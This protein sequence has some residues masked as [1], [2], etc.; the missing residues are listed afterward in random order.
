MLESLSSS[1]LEQLGHMLCIF[2]AW[3]FWNS[4]DKRLGRGQNQSWQVIQLGPKQRFCITETLE[5]YHGCLHNMQ[6]C[7]IFRMLWL[8]CEGLLEKAC[9]ISWCCAPSICAST[10]HWNHGKT[11]GNARFS[12]N[13]NFDSLGFKPASL[14]LQW[15][16]SPSCRHPATPR[17]FTQLWCTVI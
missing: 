5:E 16:G 7:S 10:L 1:G 12:Y 11:P 13:S 6:A 15:T 3:I 8:R 17:C 14:D 9:S 2:C 4:Q